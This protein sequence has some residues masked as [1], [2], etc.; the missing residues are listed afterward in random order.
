M[1]RARLFQVFIH[2]LLEIALSK[3]V[4]C[5]QQ[6]RQLLLVP[7]LTLRTWTVLHFD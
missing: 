2:K 6:Q 3:V 4:N 7:A 5:K 1:F